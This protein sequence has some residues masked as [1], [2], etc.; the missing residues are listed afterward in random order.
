M[1]VDS[2]GL[3]VGEERVV[4]GCFDGFVVGDGFGIGERWR[5]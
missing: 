3:Q 5:K 1:K 4:G 2:E